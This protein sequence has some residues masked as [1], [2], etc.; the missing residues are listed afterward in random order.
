M[1]LR[2]IGNLIIGYEMFHNGDTELGQMK[3]LEIGK[4]LEELDG[5]NNNTNELYLSIKIGLK[6]VMS[7]TFVHMLFASNLFEECNWV[8]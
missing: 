7:S 1:I 6:H 5:L 3:M 2:Y 4:W 8:S